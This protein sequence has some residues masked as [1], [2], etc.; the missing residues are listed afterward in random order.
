MLLKRMPPSEAWGLGEAE[1]E[2]GD[3]DQR[4]AEKKAIYKWVRN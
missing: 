2:S 3:K 4:I 1:Q